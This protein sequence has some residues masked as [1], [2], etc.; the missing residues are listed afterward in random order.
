MSDIS[1]G[2]AVAGVPEAAPRQPPALTTGPAA[3]MRAGLTVRN[4][5]ALA[6]PRSATR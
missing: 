5:T 2:S 4:A 1:L 6:I 3:W